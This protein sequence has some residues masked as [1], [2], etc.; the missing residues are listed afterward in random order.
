MMS[1]IFRWFNFTLCADSLTN[2][3]TIMNDKIPLLMILIKF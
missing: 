3:M 1:T 2:L